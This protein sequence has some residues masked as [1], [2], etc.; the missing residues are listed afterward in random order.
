M[1]IERH[2]YAQSGFI[3]RLEFGFPLG[4]LKGPKPPRA[5]D[6]RDPGNPQAWRV[7]VPGILMRWRATRFTGKCYPAD[8]GL[9]RLQT[10]A[11][12]TIER[13]LQVRVR[14]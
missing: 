10:L 13:V 12:G 11:T 6:E 3:V 1:P 7:A 2:V 9:Q 8:I 5:I 4:D 14:A